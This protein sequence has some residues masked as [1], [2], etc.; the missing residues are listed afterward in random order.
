MTAFRRLGD[1]DVQTMQSFQ[2]FHVEA[3]L[4]RISA[5]HELFWD[6]LSTAYLVFVVMMYIIARLPLTTLA[7]RLNTSISLPILLAV[8]YLPW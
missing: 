5:A 1:A 3:V 6:T 4:K 2:A 8:L 7:S